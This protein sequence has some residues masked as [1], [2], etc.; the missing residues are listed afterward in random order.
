MSEVMGD[1]QLPDLCLPLFPDSDYA[2]LLTAYGDSIHSGLSE[3]YP[4]LQFTSSPKRERK[5][6][7]VLIMEPSRP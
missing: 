2:W 7:P 1:G 4:T 6:R 5:Q 3:M